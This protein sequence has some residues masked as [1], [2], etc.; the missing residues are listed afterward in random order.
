MWFP[1]E[2]DVSPNQR[3]TGLVQLRYED[4]AQ[5]GRVL[6]GALPQAI[7]DVIWRRVL[8]EHTATAGLR[9]AGIVPILS[10]LVFE[11]GLGPVSV[12]KPLYAQGLYQLAHSVDE[13]GA[14][15]RLFVNMWA[16]MNGPKSRTHGPPPEGAGTPVHV[17]RIFAE[18]IF[19][20]PFAEP[21]ARKVRSLDVAG[22][23]SVP[24]ARYPFRALSAALQVPEGAK[25]LD[26]DWVQSEPV[27]FGLCHTDSNQ[28]VNSL[29]YPRLFEEAV[30]RRISALGRSTGSFLMRRVEIGYRKPF[31]AGQIAQ[32]ALKVFEL[33]GKLGA[34]GTFGLSGDTG[35]KPHCYVSVLFDD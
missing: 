29:V 5:D 25:P 34:V 3:A 7:G 19:T 20:R 2:P 12:R 35:G 9:D 13:Q 33:G 15:D 8:Y 26:L 1:T 4:V 27:A 30:L 11:G 16:T 10:R 21:H 23:P 14:V 18:H 6:V 17:G 24:E 22:L 32:I 28:H 31:F